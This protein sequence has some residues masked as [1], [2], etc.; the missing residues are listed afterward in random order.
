M[1]IPIKAKHALH[2]CRSHDLPTCLTKPLILDQDIDIIDCLFHSCLRMQ[3]VKSIII[4]LGI[5]SLTASL[6]TNLGDW[7]MQWM[8]DKG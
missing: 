2:S 1:W 6:I 4:A 3:I 8:I 7:V 5:I